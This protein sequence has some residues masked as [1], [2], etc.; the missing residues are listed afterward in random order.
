MILDEIFPTTKLN[1]ASFN[2]YSF[3]P[4]RPY[5]ISFSRSKSDFIPSI[6]FY[7]TDGPLKTSKDMLV[8]VLAIR[9]IEDCLKSVY[10]SGV[11]LDQA[12]RARE[13]QQTVIQA[14]T[15][16]SV[17]SSLPNYQE[18]FKI[19]H[20]QGRSQIYR[21]ITTDLKMTTN[22]FMAYFG[23]PAEHDETDENIEKYHNAT[24]IFPE[25][26]R[27]NRKKKLLE[28]LDHVYAPLK[29]HSVDHLFS[30]V[31]RFANLPSRIGGTY[32]IESKEIRIQTLAEDTGQTLKNIFHEYGHKQY[33]ECLT[34]EQRNE[35]KTKFTELDHSGKI[36]DAHN[37]FKKNNMIMFSKD[38]VLTYIGKNKK[39][40]A[41]NPYLITA[42]LPNE[43]KIHGTN[44]RFAL[45]GTPALFWNSPDWKVD[46]THPIENEIDDWFPTDYST[47]KATE[48]YAEAFQ[49]FVTDTLGKEAKA[50]LQP[51]FLRV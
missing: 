46:T 33:Y 31:I 51:Y 11:T 35:I 38:T 6:I 24:V 18:F 36:N 21:Y 12:K 3:K 14:R 28:I 7:S 44:A 1:E 25:T 50:F 20:L 43:L 27:P 42:I 40:A 32:A 30:G 16:P 9:K 48:W 17:I 8:Y 2:F 39:Y 23:D 13:V 41:A 22:Q 19:V 26:I 15:N 37:V 34:D 5:M 49:N 10:K 45:S 29:A 47:T 4:E